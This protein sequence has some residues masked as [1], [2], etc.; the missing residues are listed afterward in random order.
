MIIINIDRMSIS[1]IKNP[2][3][4]CFM[5]VALQCLSNTP[6]IRKFIE[7]YNSQD[8]KLISIINKY[9]LGQYKAKDIKVQCSKLLISN[10][11]TLDVS[12]K[13]ILSHLVKYSY[14]IYIYISFKDIMQRLN[15]TNSKVLSI[16]S[17]ISITEELTKGQDFEH[18][19]NGEQNDPHEFIVYLFDK[20]DNAQKTQ[21]TINKPLC[22]EELDLYSKLYFEDFKSRYEN[23][24][25]YLVKN[26]YY[27]ILNCI[28]CSKCKHK[29]HNVCPNNILCLS[30]PEINGN[31]TLYDCLDDMFKLD[32]ISYE[33]EK[34]KNT[35][36][37]L[38]EKKILSDPPSSLILTI[39]RYS[40]TKNT[41]MIK[42]NNMVYYPETLNIQKYFCG[43]DI[44]KEYKLRSIIN[45]TG[46]INGG[47]YYSY[48][49]K[50]QDD[51]KTFDDNWVCCNDSQ[52]NNITNEEAMSSQNAYMLFY[53]IE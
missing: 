17:F 10:A 12:E 23:N 16:A 24:Y 45:H 51:N 13:H 46:S 21:I 22:I 28:E 42:K 15:K 14:D 37:N 25:S 52:V 5:I 32:T 50:L 35:E 30:I 18:L 3:N 48:V 49:K 41:R 19:F 38:M 39:K 1:G 43:K 20:I 9:S 40:K 47:H 34:C 2:G 29:S 44:L 7:N 11:E 53:S 8:L 27:Y 4:N 31:I 6:V 33:C 26:L 36:S